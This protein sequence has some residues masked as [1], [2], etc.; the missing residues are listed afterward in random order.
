MLDMQDMSGRIYQMSA[1]GRLLNSIK[2]PAGN[3]KCPVELK[4]FWQSLI[5]LYFLVIYFVILLTSFCTV[6]FVCVF[7]G[8]LPLIQINRLLRPEN[9]SLLNQALLNVSLLYLTISYSE[10]A[11]SVGPTVPTGHIT[12]GPTENIMLLD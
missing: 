5:D 3:S 6:Y 4:S 11:K 10:L 1:R 12:A 7:Q 9:L 2:C 8:T